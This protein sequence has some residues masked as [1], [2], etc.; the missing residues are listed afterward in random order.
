MY[1]ASEPG[2]NGIVT[3]ATDVFFTELATRGHEPLVKSA[4]GTVRFDLVDGNDVEHWYVTLRKGD[5]EVSHESTSADT[6]VRLDRLAFDGMVSGTVN[7]L[8]ATLR[9]ELVADGDLGLVMLFQRLFPSPPSVAA[10]DV[11]ARGEE[12]S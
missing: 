11:L 2:R 12:H 6:V 5:V 4:S 3:T 1:R 8:A 9:G 7:A 10:A